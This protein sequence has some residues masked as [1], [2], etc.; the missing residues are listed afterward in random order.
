[1]DDRIE[2]LIPDISALQFQGP[3]W[4]LVVEPVQLCG[5]WH[6]TVLPRNIEVG[7]FP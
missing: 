3:E 6:V 7:I 5:L 1:M 2:Q 4:Q